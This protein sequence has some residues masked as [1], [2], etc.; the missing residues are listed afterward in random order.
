MAE[1]RRKTPPVALTIAGSDSGAGAGIQAD[2]KAF[3]AN[4][5]YGTTVITAITAQNTH[6][7]R[8]LAPVDPEL[9]GAQIT[10]VISD[11][12]VRAVKTGMLATA[13][14]V[15]VVAEFADKGAFEK[16]V[17]DPVLIS[18]T[19]ERLLDKEA[20]TAYVEKLIP[21]ATLITPNLFEVEALLGKL[22]TSID[23]MVSAARE[24]KKMG[25]RYVLIKGGHL[26]D[27][28]STDIFYDGQ[29]ILKLSAARIMT[30]NTHGTGCTLSAAITANLAK[31]FD[32]SEA[33]K[34]AKVYIT[35]TI[36]AGSL[37]QLGLGHGPVDPFIW[38]S[39]EEMN[40]G[41]QVLSE[42]KT[43]EDTDT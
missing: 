43:P 31:G 20:E 15:N 37:W 28:D 22:P 14:I 17:V 13:A 23:E 3:S 42:S 21:K 41:Q 6:E 11:F 1:R 4:R 16:L 9:V 12:A 33:V 30:D 29:T 19:G 32:V 2:L 25:V 24:F 27:G 10:A 39:Q 26:N 18:S 36:K 40:A 8:A 38:A 34:T 35:R 5:V 7:V